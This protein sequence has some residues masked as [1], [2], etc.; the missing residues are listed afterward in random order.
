LTAL[1]IIGGIIL[2]FTFLC[3]IRADVTFT[4]AEEF[5]MRVKVLGI[6]VFAIPG[7]PKKVRL[8]DYTPKALE[9]KKRKAEKKALAKKKKAEK[10]ALKKKKAASE[11]KKPA[12]KQ[13]TDVVALISLITAVVKT[14]V[15]KFAKSL[16]IKIAK[17]HVGV[18]G[19]DAAETAI[20]YGTVS[21]GV[22][23]LASLLDSTS[24]LKNP[25]KADVRIY[26]DYLSEK[27]VIDMNITVS[28][29]VGQVF[30]MVF[31]SAGTAIREL[32]KMNK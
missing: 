14:F 9:R 28:L 32:I 25:Q 23:Y 2:F 20:L 12:K 15:T 30:G 26:A 27:P 5:G 18:A 13:K 8:R 24:T 21:Q 22:C 6:T 4:Y 29:H 11:D 31:S 3:M 1:Y 17:L 10:K 16:R 19:K 7:K